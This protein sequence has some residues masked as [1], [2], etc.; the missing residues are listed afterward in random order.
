MKELS[1]DTADWAMIEAQLP[2]Q[3]RELGTQY[4]VL[5]PDVPGHLGAKL[6]D[7]AVLLRLVLHHVV[8]G[9][10]LKLTMALAAAIEL[11]DASA[12][13]LHKK[14]KKIGPYLWA[15]VQQMVG[16]QAEF[17]PE[18]WAG[19]EVL[20]L[21]ATTVQRPGAVETTARV[22]YVIRAADFALVQVQVTDQHKG[23]TLRWVEVRPGQLW[24]GD[25]IYANPPGIAWVVNRGGD[26]V[27]RYTPSALPLY[28]RAGQVF[29][30]VAALSQ[31]VQPGQC[32]EWAV[33]TA[34]PKTEPVAGRLCV[35]RLQP[36]QAERARQRL[37]QEHGNQVSALQR[38]LCEFVILFTTA[39]AQ[40]LP[41]ALVLELYRLRWQVELRIKRD[42]S[43]GHLDQLP[44]FRPDTIYSWLC[45]HVLAQLIV[46]R[47]ST[48]EVAFPPCAASGEPALSVLPCA[49]PGESAFCVLP[50]TASIESALSVPA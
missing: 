9:M 2:P 20:L 16:R 1:L 15:L 27:V 35:M 37:R 50:C 23:E 28:D 18:R 38:T 42:K 22:H 34:G 29:D 24:V 7:P 33:C 3:W 4:E 12:V 43:L 5:R 30:V 21:D 49:A 19:Y 25:R 45:A 13:A 44:N 32:G 14:M 48:A 47:I 41:T 40:R 8:T 26:V 17:A 6:S 46:G 31:L 10:S 36:E 11:V 39:D